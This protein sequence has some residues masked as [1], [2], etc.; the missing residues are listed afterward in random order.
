MRAAAALLPLLLL[1][2]GCAEENYYLD[3]PD[4]NLP[5][6]DDLDARVEAFRSGCE[7]W[8]GDPKRVADQALRRH[9][10]IGEAPWLPDPFR[11]EDY[12]VKQSPKW[13]SYVVRGYVYP[14]GYEVR[15]RVKIRPHGE[16]WCATQVSRYKIYAKPDERDDK[17]GR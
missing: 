6:P 9:L 3:L 4:I 11:P 1:L 2:A 5:E 13:G 7:T 16:I 12:E 15:Y 10:G 17:R 8:H 14:S